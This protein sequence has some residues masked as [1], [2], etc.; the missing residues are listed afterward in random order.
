VNFPL[1]F[2]KPS[3]AALVRQLTNLPPAPTVLQKIKKVMQSPEASLDQIA[4]L[5]AL[6][7]GLALRVVRMA[8]S[9]QFGGGESVSN[10]ME[11]IQ[12][13]GIKGVQE[14][15]TYALAS[16]L[17]GQPLSSYGID[18]NTLWFR[19]VACGLAAASLANNNG[20][21]Q[22]DAYTA[23]LMHGIGLVVLDR[24]A[25]Q[26]RPPHAFKSSG[27]PQDCAPA[28]RDYLGM[29][30]AD[31]GAALLEFWSFS[32]SVSAAVRH[33]LAPET[34]TTHRRLCMTL[35]VARW[36]RSLF[37]VPDELIP[38]IPSEQWLEEAG[39]AI[40]DFGPWL[41]E[42]RQGYNLAKLDLRLS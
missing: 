34:A 13:V 18:A 1:P 24:H 12:R 21:D 7:P 19:A 20:E 42:V 27:Y 10:I 30:H 26:K 33:Q 14:I 16:Q 6:E 36:A 38:E 2:S 3:P 35:A 40:G 25:I 15:V 31:A 22:A 37:C 5:V 41:D 32:D 39:I 23:G 17:V 4:E 11:A 29:T 9:A 8:R 28:E